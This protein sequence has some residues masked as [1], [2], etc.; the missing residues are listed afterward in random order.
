MPMISA[1]LRADSTLNVS[2]ARNAEA[3]SNRASFSSRQQSVELDQH[4]ANLLAT[5]YPPDGLRQLR[6]ADLGDQLL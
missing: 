1:V 4:T 5:Q 3:R 2:H 6:Q